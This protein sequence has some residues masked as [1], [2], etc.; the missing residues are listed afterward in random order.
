MK[1]MKSWFIAIA[2]V[3]VL[4]ATFVEA[5]VIPTPS[6][7]KTLLVGDAVLTNRFVYGIKIPIPLTGTQIPV[8]RGAQV[9]RGDIVAFLSPFENMNIVKRCIA[10]AGD[11]VEIADKAVYVNGER[12][13]EPYAMFTDEH[14]YRPYPCDR[15]L[16][17]ERWEK[18]ELAEVFGI[19]VRD[20]FGPV[21]VPRDHIFVM[22]DNRDV[23]YDSRY[24]G[25]L[26]T[27]YLKGKPLF[28]FFSL[29]PGDG[30]SGVNDLLTFWRWQGIRL[31]RIG[32]IV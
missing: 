15:A 25:P 30:A 5:Y 22:G 9:Q 13:C 24:W 14:T 10:R 7:E 17:Q 20:N 2:V 18:A 21:V 8:I 31:M 19:H 4:K 3:F 23:S 29:D 27:K 16:Y 26:H 6:M 32:K 28:I 12:L 11:T 1:E